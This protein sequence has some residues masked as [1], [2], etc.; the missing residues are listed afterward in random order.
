MDRI[1][2]HWAGV[3]GLS[4]ALLAGLW[5]SFMGV[6]FWTVAF[7]VAVVGVVV[8]LFAQVA[9]RMAGRSLLESVAADQLREEE[10]TETGAGGA[11]H[12][13]EHPAATGR[14]AA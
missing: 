2:S 10:K 9:G 8:L 13:R 6:G 1:V 4:S 11:R 14:R 7:R 5:M 12:S 3:A